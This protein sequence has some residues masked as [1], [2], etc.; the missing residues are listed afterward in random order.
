MTDDGV[1]VSF[2][3][4]YEATVRLTVL[5][6]HLHDC[7]SA[8]VYGKTLGPKS[9]RQDL[10]E[11]LIELSTAQVSIRVV[12]SLTEERQRGE[13]K[14]IAGHEKED[15]R[16]GCDAHRWVCGRHGLDDVSGGQRGA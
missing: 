8:C 14:R 2:S 15:H 3:C 16:H 5:T 11:V 1:S 7:L 4:A 13:A 9:V 10:S 12:L 6:V